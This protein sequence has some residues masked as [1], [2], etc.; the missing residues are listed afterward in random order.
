M[1][2]HNA[3]RQVEK[4][5]VKTNLHYVEFTHVLA[6]AYMQRRGITVKI[7]HDCTADVDSYFVY[8]VHAGDI[9]SMGFANNYNTAYN[10]AVNFYRAYS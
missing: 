8:Y 9:L 4:R 3:S 5:K 10:L 6:I 7:V 1:P 2:K